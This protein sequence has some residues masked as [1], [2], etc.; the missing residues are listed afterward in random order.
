M[1]SEA[2]CSRSSR[3][4]CRRCGFHMKARR[5]LHASPETVFYFVDSLRLSRPESLFSFRSL[6][7]GIRT[8]AKATAAIFMKK[9]SPIVSDCADRQK[10]P[11]C[12][13]RRFSPTAHGRSEPCD[14]L[15]PSP[16]V[17]DGGMTSTNQHP[18]PCY[19]NVGENTDDWRTPQDIWPSGRTA[20]GF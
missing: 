14:A 10:I 16:G 5:P 13:C 15:L 4:T 1:I 19:E 11:K 18:G 7:P 12:R 17:Q 3:R 2:A 6:F 20:A 9:R 8:R